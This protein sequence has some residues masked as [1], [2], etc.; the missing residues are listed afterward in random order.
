MRDKTAF[1]YQE[2]NVRFQKYLSGL[3]ISVISG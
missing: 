2:A 3:A 1:R